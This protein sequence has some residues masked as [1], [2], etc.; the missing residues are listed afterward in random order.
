VTTIHCK[1]QTVSILFIF[2]TTAA[3]LD[4]RTSERTVEQAPAEGNAT[5]DQKY[6][7]AAAS[8]QA[9]PAARHPAASRLRLLLEL[10]GKAAKLVRVPSSHIVLVVVWQRETKLEK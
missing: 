9:A 7:R 8:E 1:Q 4:R 10:L 5:A 6:E 2:L 3:E